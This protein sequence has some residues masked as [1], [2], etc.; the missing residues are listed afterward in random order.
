AAPLLLELQRHHRAQ[1]RTLG[2]QRSVEVLRG[3]DPVLPNR[4]DW[5]PS[6]SRMDDRKLVRLAEQVGED[7][8]GESDIPRL[9]HVP[10]GGGPGA[11]LDAESVHVADRARQLDEDARVRRV[12]RIDRRLRQ[13]LARSKEWKKTAPH[14]SDSADLDDFSPT[15]RLCMMR[16]IAA[17]TGFH[18]AL[19]IGSM[20][21]VSRRENPA[22]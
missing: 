18:D 14:Y 11:L 22:C 19:G 20:G 16:V 5:N 12:Q 4:M 10:L 7:A 3:V 9:L 2:R 13:Y 1:R 21:H 17:R 8:A 6:L 15:K